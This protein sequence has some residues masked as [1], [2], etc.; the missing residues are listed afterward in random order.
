VGQFEQIISRAVGV[1]EE[2]STHT[3]IPVNVNAWVDEG[4]APLVEALNSFKR[5]WT[6]ASCECEPGGS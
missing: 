5:V 3:E 2:M 6:A 4:I 1:R